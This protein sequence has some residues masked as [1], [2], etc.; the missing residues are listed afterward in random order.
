MSRVDHV[1][2]LCDTCIMTRQK[3]LSFPRQVSFR[4][5]EWLELVHG[6]LCGP[7]TPATSGGRRYFLLL[8]DDVSRYMWAVILDTKGATANAIKHIQAVAENESGSKLRVLRTD[9]GDEFTSAEFASYCADE[10]IQRHF[11]LPYS[12]QQNG[13][14]ER[15]NQTVVAMARALLKQRGMPARFWGEAVMTAVYI[16]NCS[17]TKTLNGMTPYV[18]WH[19]RKPAVGHLRVFGCL[20]YAKELNH[21]GKVDDRS[22]PGVFIGYAE[23]V[24]G[25]R[26]LDP[27]TQRVRTTRNI[28]FHEGQGW[29]WGKMVDDG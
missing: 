10:G 5:K 13:V 9:N 23:G 28:V 12:P 22:T 15:R 17:P 26:V 29:T 6:D 20:V 3:R 8:V 27:V 2:Q 21:V 4:A 14:A 1:E 11:S 18:A 16:L 24:K 19:G 7:V 25:Y